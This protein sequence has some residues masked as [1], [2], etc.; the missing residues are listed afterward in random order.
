MTDL[1]AKNS[2]KTAE[3]SGPRPLADRLRPGELGAVVGQDHLLG[4]GG[5]LRKMDESGVLAS[6]ILWDD[7]VIL[8]FCFYLLFY[9]I[10]VCT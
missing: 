5:P 4:P 2:D 7:R 10:M 6:M 9:Y 8:S 3:K 1:F